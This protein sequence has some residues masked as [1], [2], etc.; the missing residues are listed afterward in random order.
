MAAAPKTFKREA[1]ETVILVR[2][3]QRH[4]INPGT[5][6]EFTQ[7]EID[8]IEGTNPK[9]ISK[10]SVVSLDDPNGVDLKKL[11]VP[12]QTNQSNAPDASGG[13]GNGGNND[14]M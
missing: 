5:V 4:V 6:V 12:Q 7:A 2:N 9:A 10:Q 8:E 11:D 1:V 13:T 3:G 14:D